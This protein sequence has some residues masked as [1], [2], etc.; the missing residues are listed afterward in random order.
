[1]EKFRA[2]VLGSAIVLTLGGAGAM[3]S[4]IGLLLSI[5]EPQ[6]PIV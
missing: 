1:M 4:G 2:I 6:K 3:N 5:A